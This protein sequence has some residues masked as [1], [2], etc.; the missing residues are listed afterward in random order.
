[1]DLLRIP[2]C[3]KSVFYRKIVITFAYE[4]G[5]RRFLYENSSTENF[6]CGADSIGSFAKYRFAKFG[7]KDRVFGVLSSDVGIA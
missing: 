1:M 2:I 3:G 4:L 5:L 7:S 6:T